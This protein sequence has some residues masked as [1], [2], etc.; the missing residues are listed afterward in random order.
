MEK[1]FLNSD[2]MEFEHQRWKGEI[3]F[4]KNELESFNSKLS[5]L[6]TR[7]ADKEELAEV[8]YYQKQFIYHGGV[9]EDLLES[10]EQKEMRI[11]SLNNSNDLRENSVLSEKHIELRNRMETQRDVYAELKKNIFRFLE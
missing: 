8:G 11:S 7:W 6:I 3:S 2:N 1:P 5:E 10:I 4:W 9:I